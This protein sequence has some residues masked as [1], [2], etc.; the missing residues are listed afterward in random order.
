M[1]IGGCKV[2]DKWLKYRKER[3][4]S[5]GDINHF[6]KVARSLNETIELMDKIDEI[7]AS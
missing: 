1:E 2:L 7:Y 5:F 4:L 6:Q 3:K